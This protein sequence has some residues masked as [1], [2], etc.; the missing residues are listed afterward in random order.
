[1]CIGAAETC[2]NGGLTRLLRHD[3]RLGTFKPAHC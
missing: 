1:M 2:C 3:S